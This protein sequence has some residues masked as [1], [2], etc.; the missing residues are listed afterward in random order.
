MFLSIIV[1][2]FNAEQ[3]LGD[4]LDSLL[5]QNIAATD[6]EIIC[7]NDGST[8]KSSDILEKY[9]EKAENITVIEQKNGGVSKARNAGLSVS[10]GDYIWFV[11]SDDLI[12]KDI[13]GTIQKKVNMTKCDRLVFPN[14]YEFYDSFTDDE[15]QLYIEGTLSAN[16]QYGDGVVVSSIIKKKLLD[17]HF[18]RFRENISYGED[19]MFIFELNEHVY[20]PE[21]LDDL[22]YYYRRNSA[23]ATMTW[24]HSSAVKRIESGLAGAEIMR[25]K[26]LQAKT[27][28]SA[29]KIETSAN[30]IMFFLRPAMLSISEMTRQEGNQYLSQFRQKGLFPFQIPPECTTKTSRVTPREDWLGKLYDD[31]CLHSTTYWGF[32]LLRAWRCVHRVYKSIRN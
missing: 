6:F 30:L 15:K 8:D 5:S 11:D 28:D 20:C 10:R 23:S 17:D 22:V 1:P 31:I 21:R 29:A 26:Y 32:S 7:V 18:I 19:I 3:Y 14:V 25:E 2:V 13:L 12:S 24:S 16:N 27:G 9:K 4:C